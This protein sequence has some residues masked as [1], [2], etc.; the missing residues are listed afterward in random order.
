MAEQTKKCAHPSCQCEV[1]KDDDYCST[2]CEDAQDTTEISCD[3]G[4]PGCAL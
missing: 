2:F 4:H 1:G 3:C